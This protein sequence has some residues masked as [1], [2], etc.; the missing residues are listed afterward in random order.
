MMTSSGVLSRQGQRLLQLGMALFFYSSADGFA[1][2][3]NV[4]TSFQLN[5]IGM[6]LVRNEPLPVI[7]AQPYG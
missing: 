5:W 6:V 4:V 7:F 2:P 3:V 1:I